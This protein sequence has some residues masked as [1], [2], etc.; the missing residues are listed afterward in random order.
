MKSREQVKAAF[1][2]R[3]ESVASWARRNGF[4]TVTARRVLAGELEG[5]YGEAHRVA[6]ALGLKAAPDSAQGA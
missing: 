4:E 3:G 1:V 6:V 2:A 5:R